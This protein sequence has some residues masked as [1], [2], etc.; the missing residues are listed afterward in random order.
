MHMFL[1]ITLGALLSV[2]TPRADDARL[3]VLNKTDNTLSI[4]DP[5]SG[6]TVATVPTGEGPH[7]VA[8]SADGKTAFVANYGNQQPGN[9]LSIIDLA[10]AKETKRVELGPLMRPHGLAVLDDKV[11]FTAE[12]NRAIGRLDPT[13]GKVDRIVGFGQEATHMLVLSPDGRHIYT[14][15]IG[16]KSISVLDRQ[17]GK[18]EHIAV[19]PEPEGIDI[20]SDG[21]ELWVSH[22]IDGLVTVID[23]AT[24]HIKGTLNV[25]SVAIRVKLTPDCKRALVSDPQEGTLMVIDAATRKE[26]KRLSVGELPVGILIPPDGKRAFV[27]LMGSDRLAVVDLTSLEVSGHVATG[28]GPDGMAWAAAPTD[29]AS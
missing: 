2:H 8:V 23:T 18:L 28:R 3:L 1:T 20:S 12:M 14:A 17:S 6:S 26:I 29:R 24:R 27:A 11:Y 25:G 4:I 7:E 13:A 9:T 21:S 10:A 22:R 19:G 5:A 15:N 16:S